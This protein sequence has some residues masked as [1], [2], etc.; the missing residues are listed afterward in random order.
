MIDN[1]KIT[2][3]RIPDEAYIFH[4][5]KKP[6]LIIIEKKNQNVDGSV[7]TKLWEGPSLLREYQIFMGD[8]FDI[9]YLYTISSFLK[10]HL[11]SDNKKYVILNKIL[12]ENG[13]EI[14]YGED[15]DYF[16]KINEYL[17][18]LNN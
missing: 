13:I 11:Q 4:R 17:Q 8:I 14:F 1:H 3:F 16:V 5:E 18:N 2:P 12:K 7:E 15:I 6:L 10:T 9:K